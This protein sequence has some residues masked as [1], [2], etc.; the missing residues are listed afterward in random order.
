M[1]VDRQRSR[2]PQSE[3]ESDNSDRGRVR[4]RGRDGSLL[5]QGGSGRSSIHLESRH[6]VLEERVGTIE[7]Q[8]IKLFCE[9]LG[10]FNGSLQFRFYYLIY[11]GKK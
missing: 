9:F 1:I 11:L 8:V 4:R 7:E 5:R 2:P 10:I 3:D 6:E